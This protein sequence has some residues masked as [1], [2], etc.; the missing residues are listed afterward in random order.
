MT[1][2]EAATAVIQEVA[3]GVAMGRRWRPRVPIPRCAKKVCWPRE[4]LGCR[5]RK[6]EMGGPEVSAK[7]TGPSLEH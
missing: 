4:P 1:G 5:D 2:S 7:M 3:E 6:A